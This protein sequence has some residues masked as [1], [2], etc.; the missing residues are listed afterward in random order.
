LQHNIDVAVSGEGV[1][2]V[3]C[4]LIA[5]AVSVASNCLL[6]VAMSKKQMRLGAET[7]LISTAA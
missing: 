2:V 5:M 3:V 7:Q 1:S 4:V 6:V